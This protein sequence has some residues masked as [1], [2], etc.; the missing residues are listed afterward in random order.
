MS[1]VKELE[2]ADSNIVTLAISPK[3]KWLASGYN[4]DVMRIWSVPDGKLHKTVNQPGYVR[5]LAF[6]PNGKFI[7]CFIDLDAC[8][9]DK[10]GVTYKYQRALGGSHCA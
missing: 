2:A 5:G 1:V 9:P 3:G 6:S 4:D 10:Y 8:F 7:R